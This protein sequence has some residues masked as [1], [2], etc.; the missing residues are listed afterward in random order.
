[1]HL[2][3]FQERLG[4]FAAPREVQSTFPIAQLCAEAFQFSLARIG[5]GFGSA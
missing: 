4:V 3:Q 1:M 2:I 5:A